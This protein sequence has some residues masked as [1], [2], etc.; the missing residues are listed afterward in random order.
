MFRDTK[1]EKVENEISG[2]EKQELIRQI[3]FLLSTIKTKK[4]VGKKK[5]PKYKGD[6]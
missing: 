5:C 3:S 1:L 2:I 6:N 4:N